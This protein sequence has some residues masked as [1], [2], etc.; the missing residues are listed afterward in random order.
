MPAQLRPLLYV[1]PLTISVELV[2]DVMFWGRLPS[3]LAYAGTTLL[4]LL[5]AWF[6]FAFFQK[7]R[8]GFADVL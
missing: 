2:R 6:G 7:T 3:A 4:F 8:K 1:S 5:L